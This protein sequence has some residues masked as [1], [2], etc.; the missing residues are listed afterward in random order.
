[1]VTVWTTKVQ[2]KKWSP[3]CRYHKLWVYLIISDAFC[4]VGQYTQLGVAKINHIH[5]P[6]HYPFYLDK[7]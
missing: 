3:K 6:A 7:F 2:Q 5:E 4:I 1:M